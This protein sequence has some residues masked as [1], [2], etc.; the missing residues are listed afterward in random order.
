MAASHC[1]GGE[2]RKGGPSGG[3]SGGK[4]QVADG[5][6]KSGVGG[7]PTRTQTCD[8]KNCLR[9]DR[10]LHGRKSIVYS[11]FATAQK[12]DLPVI[13]IGDFNVA[14]DKLEEAVL[15]ERAK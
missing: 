13:L 8:G 5:T 10:A 14:A 15:L 7:K 6:S 2:G 12:A 4:K 1:T 11:A 3:T 9:G